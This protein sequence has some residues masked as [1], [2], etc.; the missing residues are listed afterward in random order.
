MVETIDKFQVHLLDKYIG[1]LVFLFD[2]GRKVL[3]GTNMPSVSSIEII[4]THQ[5]FDLGVD[6]V[7]KE[8]SGLY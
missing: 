6:I 3:S 4:Q 7:S 1:Q 2:K 8:E 5:L